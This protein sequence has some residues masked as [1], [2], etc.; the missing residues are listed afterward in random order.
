MNRS[1]FTLRFICRRWCIILVFV[2]VISGSRTNLFGHFLTLSIGWKGA[3][4]G[5]VDT[6][7]G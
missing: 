5:R 2:C 1:P 7:P 4:R 3:A 6:A